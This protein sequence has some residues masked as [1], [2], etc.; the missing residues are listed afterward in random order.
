MSMAFNRF[1]PEKCTHDLTQLEKKLGE[2]STKK[3][4]KSV[5]EDKTIHEVRALLQ[6]SPLPIGTVYKNMKLF[7][8]LNDFLAERRTAVMQSL[9]P[10]ED[11]M[12]RIDAI[13]KRLTRGQALDK[14]D[15]QAY[16][17]A[18]T[19]F[20]AAC[21][22]VTALQVLSDDYVSPVLKHISDF[23]ADMDEIF[24]Q[25]ESN[26][27]VQYQ[28][29]A[30][31]LNQLAQPQQKEKKR[32]VSASSSPISSQEP[33]KLK[34]VEIEV[35]GTKFFQKLSENKTVATQY[36]TFLTTNIG[37][38]IRDLR[39]RDS[40]TQPGITMQAAH[41]A[42]EAK[43]RDDQRLGRFSIEEQG[44]IHA[45]KELGGNNLTPVEVLLIFVNDQTYQVL[46]S[47]IKNANL[48]MDDSKSPLS[49]S[50]PNQGSRTSGAS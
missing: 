25:S 11:E 19:S 5:N 16:N 15:E 21:S 22:H 49:A 38:Y 18:E 42:K 2:I 6:T 30:D 27:T 7:S 23:V 39:A 29:R 34:E 37:Q 33:I 47:A 20:S 45:Y 26:S 41:A 31:E 3:E 36:E 13:E 48:S 8:K 17:E 50:S 35:G 14:K 10:F 1:N 32:E 28:V 24:A 4:Y 43:E 44:M 12:K 40:N 9:K 46:K